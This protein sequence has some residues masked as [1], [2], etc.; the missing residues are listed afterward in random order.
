VFCFP[1]RFSHFSFQMKMKIFVFLMFNKQ[2]KFPAVIWYL[3][4]FCFYFCEKGRNHVHFASLFCYKKRRRI[5]Y[6]PHEK[7]FFDWSNENV[8]VFVSFSWHWTF[9]IELPYLTL[10]SYSLSSYNNNKK[11][12]HKSIKLM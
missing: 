10:S 3:I 2:K 12:S 5:Q 8:C 1:E 11:K 9:W 4:R 6:F 7:L